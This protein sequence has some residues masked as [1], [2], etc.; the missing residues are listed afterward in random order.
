MTSRR[1]TQRA[2]ILAA[3]RAGR[4][5]DVPTV[6]REFGCFR[7]AARIAEL[8]REGHIVLTLRSETADGF[9]RYLLIGGDVDA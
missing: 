5:L 9:A 4:V 6:Q 8:R 7:L 1:A 2:S 3:L